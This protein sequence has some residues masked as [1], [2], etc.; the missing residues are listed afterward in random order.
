MKI[1][2]VVVGAT[3]AAVFLV[4]G[5]A[6]AQTRGGGDD[7]KRMERAKQYL[8]WKL[9]DTLDDLDADGRQREVVHGLKDELFAE[10]LKLH[11]S[12]R[13]V[14][15]EQMAEGRSPTPNA[16]TARAAV[17]RA[18]EGFRAFAYRA[19]DA[20]MTLHGTLRPE[21]RELLSQ[22]AAQGHRGCH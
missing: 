22:K 19:V 2:N 1:R 16:Q 18:I 3:A 11:A 14:R 9:N 21:Q 7:S 17:D 20:G 6:W 5:L 4:A 15:E 13:E 10:G 8:T 12:G